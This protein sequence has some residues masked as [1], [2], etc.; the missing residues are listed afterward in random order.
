MFGVDLNQSVTVTFN[1]KPAPEALRF[2]SLRAAVVTV[3]N[4][5]P[6]AQASRAF[7]CTREGGLNIVEIKALYHAMRSLAPFGI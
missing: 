7:I 3:A 4:D 6:E 5:L 1:G 2:D